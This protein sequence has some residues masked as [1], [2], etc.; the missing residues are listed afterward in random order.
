MDCTI[1][2]LLPGMEFA[3]EVIK[4]AQ[5]YP[6][7]SLG[8]PLDVGGDWTSVGMHEFL[9]VGRTLMFTRFHY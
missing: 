8:A 7:D 3:G 5:I 9:E 2:P 6:Q 1:K 4:G